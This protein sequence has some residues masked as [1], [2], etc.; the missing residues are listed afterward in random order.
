MAEST[1]PA[2][3]GNLARPAVEF[4]EWLPALGGSRLLRVHGEAAV[5]DPPALVLRGTA[6]ERRIEPRGQSRFTRAHEWRASYL[7]PAELVTAGWSETILEWPA[8]TRIPLP[9]PPATPRAEI[10]DPSVLTTLRARRGASPA[11]EPRPATDASPAGVSSPATTPL[12]PPAAPSSAAAAPS[13]DPVVPSFS[14]AAR[15]SVPVGAWTDPPG[16]FSRSVFEAEAVW[17]AKRAELER[18]INRAAEAIG[19]AREGEREA[20]DAVLA[21]LAGVRADLRAARAARA[22]DA[23]TIAVLTAELEAERI[24]HAV[25]RR[26]AADLRSAL[27]QER[28]GHDG[29]IDLRTALERERAA[30]AQAEHALAETREEGSALM[31]RIAELNRAAARDDTPLDR[32]AREHAQSAAAA[33]R[34]PEQETGELVANLEAAAAALRARTAITAPTDGLPVAAP[35]DAPAGGG[36]AVA[37]RP[38]T[39]MALVGPAARPLRRVLVELAAQDALAAGQILAALLPAQGSLFDSPIAYDLTI[40]GVGTFAITVVD[41]VAG[42]QRVSKRRSRREAAFELRA[43][44]LALAELLAGDE[45]RLGRFAGRA[46]VTRRRRR[47]RALRVLP[48]T[49]M[50]LAEA[51]AAGA[52][53]EPALVYR[54]L[55]FAIEP[56]W[57]AGHAFTVAQQITDPVPR[58]WY[59]TVRD[60][61]GVEVTEDE[62]PADATVTMTRA[63]F[64][65]LLRDDPSAPHERP[66]VQGDRA[67]V[68]LLK[69]WTDRARGAT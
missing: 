60:G 37:A 47:A 46:R 32:R 42:V 39:S 48:A 51:V 28:T 69:S 63:A 9:D 41:G 64:D 29:A 33:E 25:T 7:I 61:A 35:D 23:D 2:V 31:A 21:A 6:G 1:Q 16:A 14:A 26:T 20:R 38:G 49:R 4:A 17:T 68:A 30:R 52:R 18:E 44:P 67:A 11:N 8:G 53:L 40:A 19:R 5:S 27:A 55:P 65:R 13:S 24:A 34:R 10:V 66:L 22:A 58:T 36:N 56:E 12:P 15:S 57:T 43:D 45:R 59:L 54:T 50:S 62:R 3:P